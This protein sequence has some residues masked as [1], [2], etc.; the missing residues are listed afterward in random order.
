MNDRKR[1][2]EGESLTRICILALIP[3]DLNII[4]Q[5]LKNNKAFG[6]STEWI[7]TVTACTKQTIHTEVIQGTLKHIKKTA[8]Q[9]QLSD[10]HAQR[11]GKDMQ[12]D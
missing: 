4:S 2:G 8:A 1:Q 11:L 3:D 10:L 9:E 7:M 5:N 12:V 6:F